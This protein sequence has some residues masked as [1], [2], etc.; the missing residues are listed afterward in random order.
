FGET[1]V[2]P[3]PGLLQYTTDV[4]LRPT[5]NLVVRINAGL[6]M[7]TGLVTWRFISLDPATNLP[8]DDPLAGFLPP[9]VTPPAGQ[10]SVLFTVMPKAGLL[11][12]T[13]IQNQAIVV[14]DVNPPITT[15]AWLNTL[16]NTQPTSQV[17]A[18]AAT[19]SSP[20]FSV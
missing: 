12:D 7:A 16:D 3:P 15:P 19:Q 20:S 1:L 17:L 5:N 11:T 8:T 9:N 13:R 2:T 10:G 18:L 14:F 6:D 4:D